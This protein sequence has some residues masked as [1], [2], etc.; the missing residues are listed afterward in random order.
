MLS[1]TKVGNMQEG[2]FVLY[3]SYAKSKID[4][5]ALKNASQMAEAA[6]MLDAY[7]KSGAVY[8][9][10]QGEVL[11]SDLE[12]G[13][14]LIC[15]FRELKEKMAPTLVFIP[16]WNEAEEEMLYDVTVVPKIQQ[17]I[18]TGDSTTNHSGILFVG[19]FLVIVA[20]LFWNKRL[21]KRRNC[22]TMQ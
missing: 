6:R 1:C 22:D 15:G 3:D 8:S 18:Q 10:E 5:H 7:K 9:S 14:Y 11:I 21:R 16:T 2:E 20:L 4:L 12:E 13:V 17:K 19:S